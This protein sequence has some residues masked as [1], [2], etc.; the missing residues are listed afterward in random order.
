MVVVSYLITIALAAF[1]LFPF[2]W[3][4]FS[5]L[6]TF[7]SLYVFPPIYLP[8]RLSFGFYEKVLTETPFIQ[9]FW[10]SFFVSVVSTLISVAFATMAAWSL[11]RSRFRGR[12]FLMRSVLLA[13]LFPQILI[14]TPLFAVIAALGLANSYGGLILAY[15]TF[16]FPFSTWMLTAYFEKIPIQIEEAG[17]IDGASNWTVF[18]RLVLPLVAPG[19]VTVAI[20]AFINAWNEFLYG[21][22]ILGGGDKR[23]LPIGLYNFIGG[24]FG[25]WGEM[26]AATT[27][28]MLPTLIL[29]FIIQRRLVSGLT[30]GAVKD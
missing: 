11:A 10:N 1:A 6:K 2:L 24:E 26:M 25:Q 16:T 29:F 15:V 30:A 3:I 17:R 14:V 20:F 12:L 7:E 9:F 8:D 5:S 18:T 22:V 27:M 4:C 23:T 19:L 13:Y 28:T 21:L